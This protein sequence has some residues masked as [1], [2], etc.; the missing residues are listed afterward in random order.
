M[1]QRFTTHQTFPVFGTK[2]GT[3]TTGVELESTYQT[4]E[5]TEAYKTFKTAGFTHFNLDVLY[6]MG[7]AETSN[8][9]E[10]KLESSPDGTNWYRI[11]TDT[12]S[13]G[14][15][16]LVAREFTFV[17]TNG[18][19]ATISIPLEIE[20]NYMRASAKETG[21]AAN[22]GTIYGEITLSGR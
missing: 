1:S 10:I 15:S 20:Y 11:P 7:A 21:V 5:I 3:T 6:T 8:S 17:G 19:A 4:T 22:K 13:G 2:V 14:T 18:A 9:I 12:T 16:T